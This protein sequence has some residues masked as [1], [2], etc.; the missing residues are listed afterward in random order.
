MP[1]ET[2]SQAVPHTPQET[3]AHGSDRPPFITRWL[4]STNHKDI[5]TLY[6]CFSMLAGVL[7]TGLSVAMRM[8]LQEPGLQFFSDPSTYNVLVTSHGL[9][10]IF[11]VIMPALIGGFGNWLV[12]LMIGAPDM[13][14]P[15]MN[16]IS[17]WLLVASFMLFLISLFV[18]GAPG[19]DGHSGG[20]TLYPPYSTI[21]QPGPA[22]DLV[23]FSIHLSGAASVLGAINFIT[24]IFNMRAPGMTLFKMPLFAWSMLVDAFMLLFAL[25]VLAGAVTML[26]TDR[27]FGTTFFEPAG[28]GDPILFQH[29][30]WFFGH[31]EVYIMILPA[32]GIISHVISTFSKKPIFG[33]LGMV[34][35]MIAIGAI[36]FVVWAHHMYTTGISLDTQRYFA[37]ASMVIAVPT[38]IKVFSWLATMWGGSI[39]FR[40]PMLWATGFVLLFTIGGVTGV[41]LAN[42]GIDHTLQDTYYVVAHFH[43]VL[44]LGA[45]FAIFSGFYFWFPK[46]TGYLMSE[47][48]GRL[49]FWLTFVGVNLVFFPQHFLGLAGMPRRYADYPDAFAGWNMIS[50]IGSYI[51]AVG[52]AVFFIAVAEAFVRKRQAGANP[53]GVGATTL[54]WTLTS[55]PPFHQFNELPRIR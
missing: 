34:W 49:H 1:E 32:F 46:M 29:L 9:V 45:A 39:T 18:P 42:P 5:G 54:E 43:Y 23:I 25:P 38:G 22:V 55:P 4:F 47:N 17:F 33:Y 53:W 12:P 41:V 27:N 35:A 36:G 44:S 50:S 6:L 8:E 13:A 48:L 24:T 20:W 2:A 30:F 26:L 52:L 14:F 51:S 31:P 3:G 10:M 16:N 28:G 21:G 37:F 15:R 11:F 7:G 40:V 19:S